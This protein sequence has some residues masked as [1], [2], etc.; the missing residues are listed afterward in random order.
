VDVTRDLDDED[1]LREL[2]LRLLD[3]ECEVFLGG[4]LAPLRRAS[5]NPIAIAC[6][7]FFTFLP[8]LPE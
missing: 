7:G 4:T 3:A 8:E 2:L 5:D 6:C 1:R